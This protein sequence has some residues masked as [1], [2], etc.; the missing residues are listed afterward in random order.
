MWRIKK[1]FD[2]EGLLAPGAML[3]KDPLGHVKNTHTFPEIE[4]VANACI[5]YGYCEPVC[6]SRH[7][8]TTPRQ[9]IALRREMMRHEPGSPIQKALLKEYK[10]DAV[11]TC[12]GDSSYPLHEELTRSATREEAD[13]VAGKN[14]DLYLCANRTC[15][16]GME[17]ATH[18]PYESFV[19][20]LEE[21]TRER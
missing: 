5:E 10:Y 8:T 7:L 9:R 3:N 4:H 12:A 17:H 11:Q 15:E 18:A 14:L 1:L 6:P 20:A 13:E 19:Y 21:L 2:P 16:V